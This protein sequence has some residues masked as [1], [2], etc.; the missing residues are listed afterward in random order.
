MA[1]DL[2]SNSPKEVFL[3]FES[4]AN[5][6]GLRINTSKTVHTTFGDLQSETHLQINDC[7]FESIQHFV[8]LGY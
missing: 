4:T 5:N 6:M 7:V 1:I 8:Y 2:V 3:A